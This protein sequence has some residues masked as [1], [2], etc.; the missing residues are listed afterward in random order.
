M[1][2]VAWCATVSRAPLNAPSSN[3]TAQ[4]PIRVPRPK[5]DERRRHLA[6]PRERLDGGD[7]LRRAVAERESAVGVERELGAVGG[8]GGAFASE[9]GCDIHA[10]RTGDGPLAL[11]RVEGHLEH[12]RGGAR[13]IVGADVV[14][15]PVPAPGVVAH[16][17]VGTDGRDHGRDVGGHLARIRGG[18]GARGRGTGGLR[19]GRTPGHPGVLVATWFTTGPARVRVP[20]PAVVADAELGEGG[21]ELALPLGRELRGAREV[22]EV[23]G[24]DPASLASRAGDHGDRGAAADEGRDRSPGEDRLVV[25]VGVHEQHPF[26]GSAPPDR[27]R[28]EYVVGLDSRTPADYAGWVR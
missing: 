11:D 1:S 15:M 24:D 19:A 23:G 3:A 25:G 9:H 10:H 5:S 26:H 2:T 12:L 4:L 14:G 8:H 6:H 16:H 20:E 18:E 21:G 17:H 13:G 28:Q 7:G 27:L 22:L